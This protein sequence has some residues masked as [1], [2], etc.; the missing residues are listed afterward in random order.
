[1]I[2]LML[3]VFLASTSQAKE[4]YKLVVDNY[5]IYLDVFPSLKEISPYDNS[6]NGILSTSDPQVVCETSLVPMKIGVSFGI[7]FKLIGP[8]G[9]L[10]ISHVGAETHHPMLLDA[11]DEYSEV[12]NW[13][14][15]ISHYE[16][17]GYVGGVQFVFEDQHELVKGQWK[18]VAKVFGQRVEQSFEVGDFDFPDVKSC[19][20]L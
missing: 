12:S 7:R 2:F 9:K 4:D 5:G 11:E 20:K 18:L 14:S 3:L 16:K 1:M 6:T 8:K 17:G 10:N 15:T 19:K 13:K